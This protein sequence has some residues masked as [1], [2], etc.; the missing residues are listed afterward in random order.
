MNEYAKR[1]MERQRRERH[2][3]GSP[4]EGGNHGGG[5]GGNKYFIYRDGNRNPYGS[6]G[7]YVDS[8][9]DMY[10]DMNYERDGN[11]MN[12]GRGRDMNYDRGYGNDMMYDKRDMAY[13]YA[14]RNYGRDYNS[15]YGDRRSEKPYG[16]PNY[17][18][19]S[20][21]DERDGQRDYAY[22]D[23]HG[24]KLTKKDIKKWEKHLEN[25]DGTM[26]RKYSKD[27][28]LPAAQQ[29]GIKFNEYSEDEFAMAVNM[30]Y[31]D[32]CKSVGGDMMMYIKM[33]KAFL[34]DDDFDGKGSEKLALY[35]RCIAEQEQE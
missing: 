23:A 34:E 29:L 26:G 9:M 2:M 20:M 4:E 6:R 33:A 22:T 16:R 1:Y 31:S 5:Y 3:M 14:D 18:F 8:R 30:L 28:I 15:G 19:D 7:G 13:D 12:Y 10:G 35:Y 27:Q 21:G 17:G 25:A 24:T 32:Y 11:D